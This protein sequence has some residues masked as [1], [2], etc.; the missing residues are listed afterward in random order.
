MRR[1]RR[2]RDDGEEE[3]RKRRRRRRRR[4]TLKTRRVCLRRP[5]AWPQ[6]ARPETKKMTGPGTKAR[7]CPYDRGGGPFE[8][9][10]PHR[11]STRSPPP[12]TQSVGLPFIFIYF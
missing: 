5:T 3:G 7:I 12:S 10:E 6:P 8:P 1:R 2:R 4:P 11:T 9:A